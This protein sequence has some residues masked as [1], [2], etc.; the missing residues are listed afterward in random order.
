[1]INP[2]IAQKSPLFEEGMREGHLV[3]RPDGSVWR[4]AQSAP[5][6]G[7]DA[8]RSRLPRTRK[9]LLSPSAA[10]E[11]MAG[12]TLAH[13]RASPRVPVRTTAGRTRR[14]DIPSRASGPMSGR[15]RGHG[16]TA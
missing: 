10:G 5:H 2:Y 7:E 9:R 1:W 15:R 8:G 12:P 4:A 3:R 6:P 11:L 14:P 16:R 13:V